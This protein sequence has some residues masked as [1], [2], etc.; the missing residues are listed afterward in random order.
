MH[1][2]AESRRTLES[3]NP[4]K[5]ATATDPAY[6]IYTSGSTGRP[7][8]VSVP[9]RAVLRLVLNTNYVQLCPTDCVAQASN[10]S[11]DAATFE[12]WG[13]LLNGASLIGI[14]QGVLL[15]PREFSRAIHEEKINTLFLTPALF[16]Q[17][18]SEVPAAFEQLRYLLVGGE[19]VIQSG[20]GKYSSTA[21]RSIF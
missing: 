16:N 13:A 21:R 2:D 12:I 19:R 20:S 8:G 10:A 3:D 6:V 1:V 7:K 9:H 14:S 11:F 18:A 17:L 5:S 4:A 15:S